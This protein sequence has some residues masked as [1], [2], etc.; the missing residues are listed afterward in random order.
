M[1][2][3]TRRIGVVMVTVLMRVGFRVSRKV[4]AR[5]SRKV[6]ARVSRGTRRG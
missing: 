3:V 2:R 4:V 5:T 6:M 1:T